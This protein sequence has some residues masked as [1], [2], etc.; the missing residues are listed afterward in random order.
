MNRFILHA[1]SWLAV[2][3]CFGWSLPS[4]AAEL[5]PPDRPLAEVIDH[6]IN[7]K[8][9]QAGVTPSPQ[10]DEGTLVRRLHLDLAGRIPMPD[11]VQ[12]YL[13]SKD[14]QK[15]AQLVERLMASPW[16][17]RHATTEF[18]TLL[19]G[20]ELAGPDLRPY[21]L[22]ALKENRPWN[23]MFRELLGETEGPNKPEAFV[24]QRL[25]DPDVLTR[26]VSSLF[27]GINISCA[28]CHRHPYV[29]SLTQDYFFGMKAFFSRSYDFQGKLLEKQYIA[30]AQYKNKAG[31]T[32]DVKVMFLNGTTV[33]EPAVDVSDLTKAIQEE[34]KRI[35]ELQKTFA[36]TK[37]LPPTLRFSYRKQ[38]VDI[39][40]RPENQELL[41]RS[42]VNRLWYR[43]YGH[44]LVMRIDQMHS[45][46]PP[47]HPEL[48]EWLARDLI[49]HNYDLRRLVQGLVSSQAY[50]RS[51]RWDKGTP[52]PPEVFAVA[53]L[54]PLTPMQ[55]GI[56]V[57]L[58]SDPT[59][60]AA[61]PAGDSF[62]KQVTLWES[63]ALKTFG[64]IIEEPQEGLQVNVSEALILSNDAAILK[65]LGDKLVVQLL[66]IGDRQQQVEK[67][68]WTVLS[69][70]PTADEVQ[71]LSDYVARRAGPDGKQVQQGLQQMVWAL[72]TSAEFRFNH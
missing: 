26:D 62:D 41:A 69:R 21:L 44:G 38:L 47:S 70:L 35:A 12:A 54:R 58:A 66:K 68:I 53:N 13:E 9:K 39:A 3:L 7:A 1:G 15:R 33:E 18:N 16:Y 25:K 32:R 5:L 61:N 36:K 72:L 46:N 28:Q 65:M 29:K 19:R 11:E 56:S 57:R 30:P 10:A 55:F 60:L 71:T 67:A 22:V 34:T 49:G 45:E 23:Q 51:S 14:P 59:A 4:Q 6:Y 42:I 43:F 2:M 40:L 37:E 24:L 31:Q 17:V 8:L 48:L 52:P 64:R 63:E 20:P 50:S 27:F